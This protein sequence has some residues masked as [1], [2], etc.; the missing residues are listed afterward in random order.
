MILRISSTLLRKAERRNIQVNEPQKQEE[1]S[2]QPQ[3]ERS[4][5]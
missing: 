1:K 2:Q 5:V 3:D 4:K